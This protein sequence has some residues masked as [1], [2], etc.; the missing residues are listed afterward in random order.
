MSYFE[1]PFPSLEGGDDVELEDVEV[2]AGIAPVEPG[3]AVSVVFGPEEGSGVIIDLVAEKQVVLNQDVAGEPIGADQ[4]ERQ[5][6]VS[7]HCPVVPGQVVLVVGLVVDPQSVVRVA[8]LVQMG[9]AE[10]QTDVVQSLGGVE[11][12]VQVPL[13]SPVLGDAVV[14]L[15]LDVVVGL[16]FGVQGPALREVEPE[17][18]LVADRPGGL[19]VCAL[20][21]LLADGSLDVH[22]A[23]LA[24]GVDLRDEQ[25]VVDEVVGE[26]G[27]GLAGEI[28]P[29]VNFN[30]LRLGHFINLILLQSQIN[31][32]LNSS[33]V[34]SIN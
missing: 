23:L 15:Q 25:L 7:H 21:L 20:G 2:S 24:L 34:A 10:T 26:E 9:S 19:G 18:S 6:V 31:I 5:L 13:L 16:D 22:G 11:A 12:C 32:N 14:Q 29:W 17:F 28:S 4:P 33:L 30:R 8:H 27:V 1:S 3:L